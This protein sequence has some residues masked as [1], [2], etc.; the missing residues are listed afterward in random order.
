MQKVGHLHEKGSCRFRE[1]LF[2]LTFDGMLCGAVGEWSA[3][4][5]FVYSTPPEDVR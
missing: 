1:C 2:F 4:G 5:S 3:V